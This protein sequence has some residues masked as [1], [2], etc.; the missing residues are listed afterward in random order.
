MRLI[1]SD[2]RDVRERLARIEE[3]VSHLPGTGQL[4]GVGIAIVA[5]IFAALALLPWFYSIVG[6]FP[7]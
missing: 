3:R 2:I 5:L 6:W 1:A 4:W 7:K